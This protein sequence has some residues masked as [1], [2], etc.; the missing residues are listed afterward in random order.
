MQSLINILSVIRGLSLWILLIRLPLILSRSPY[1]SSVEQLK[2]HMGIDF[3]PEPCVLNSKRACQKSQK[4]KEGRKTSKEGQRGGRKHSP[5]EKQG[6]ALT[7][8][9]TFDFAP[10]KTQA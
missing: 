6:G 5:K 8:L 7:G 4:E 9:H 3:R 2:T 10:K 1:Q